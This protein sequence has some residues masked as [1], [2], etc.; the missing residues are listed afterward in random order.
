MQF[1]V[2]IGWEA[3]NGD[4]GKKRTSNEDFHPFRERLNERSLVEASLSK[5]ESTRKNVLDMLRD[6]PL[7]GIPATIDHELFIRAS[8]LFPMTCGFLR[9]PSIEITGQSWIHR[10]REYER[11][12]HV[13]RI[14]N[15]LRPRH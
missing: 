8:R 3:E 4:K 12:E 10:E 11:G 15:W 2:D 6:Y 1:R 5:A 13:Y 9:H 14:G 7:V